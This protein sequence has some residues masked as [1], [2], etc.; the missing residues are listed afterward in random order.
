ML[1]PTSIC[2]HKSIFHIIKNPEFSSDTDIQ[3]TIDSIICDYLH[4]CYAVSIE[5]SQ[6]RRG[7]MKANDETCSI[8]SAFVYPNPS[9]KEFL[10]WATLI[11]IHDTA[12]RRRNWT[13]RIGLTRHDASSATLY[14]AVSYSDHQA[15]SFSVFRPPV[16]TPPLLPQ[17]LLSH[18]GLRCQSGHYALSD[19]PWALTGSDIEEFV[20]LLYD[21]S[22]T[23]P[24]VLITCPDL[25]SP[26]ALCR[27]ALGNLIVCWLDDPQVFDLLCDRL[28]QNLLFPW[29]SV[30]VFL[31]FSK[32]ECFH[33]VLRPE[34]IQRM[35]SQ[36]ALAGI[37]RAY[38]T[39]PTGE[40]RR[41]FIDLDAVYSLLR[42]HSIA[43]MKEQISQL[44]NRADQLERESSRLHEQCAAAENTRQALEEKLVA[45]DIPTYEALLEEST[46]NAEQL[47]SGIQT[48]TEALYSKNDS[49]LSE[50]CRSDIPALKQLAEAILFRQKQ[51]S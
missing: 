48:F 38:C 39:C 40:E 49:V 46:E 2:I 16:L 15:G 35:G 6:L 22:R 44:R 36:E 25:V 30:K 51:C 33:P 13:V 8:R 50:Q 1:E 21:Q 24:I 4:R 19:A 18:P 27:L 37:Y 14:H 43:D 12:L 23:L 17:L 31:P 7:L 3:E 41:A 34:E 10:H 47:R 26:S 9:D 20:H 42:S 29:D 11:R 32:G 28:P 45:S 5:P